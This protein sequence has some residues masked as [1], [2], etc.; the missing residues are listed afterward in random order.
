MSQ[1]R[2]Q[3]GHASGAA[4]SSC[5]LRARGKQGTKIAGA[6]PPPCTGSGQCS[7]PGPRASL[8]QQA[9]WPQSSPPLRPGQ[10]GAGGAEGPPVQLCQAGLLPTPETSFLC[11]AAPCNTWHLPHQAC[12]SLGWTPMGHAASLLAACSLCP[13]S[14]RRLPPR[15][16]HVTEALPLFPAGLSAPAVTVVAGAVRWKPTPSLPPR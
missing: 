14:A 6:S 11:F 3:H 1:A 5:C 7:G 15:L 2:A 4:P 10:V 13:L 16:G 12:A 9:A 8:E